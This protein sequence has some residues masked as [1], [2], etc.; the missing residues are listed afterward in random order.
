MHQD[1]HKSSIFVHF[2]PKKEPIF[3]Y[4]KR[5]Q[6][7]IL[8]STKSCHPKGK[9]Y[10]KL[11]K[12]EIE[13]DRERKDRQRE[14]ERNHCIYEIILYSLYQKY[15][16]ILLVFIYQTTTDNNIKTSKN[17]LKTRYQTPHHID[18]YELSD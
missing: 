11:R 4:S 14:K 9:H 8:L 3:I 1:K 18:L 7:D 15:I 5:L 10:I 16:K 17:K 6:K 2:L 13:R 12:R